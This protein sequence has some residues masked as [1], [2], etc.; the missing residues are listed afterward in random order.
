[1]VDARLT[2]YPFSRLTMALA[3][4]IFFSDC[5][6]PEGNTV[7]WCLAGCL[8]VAVALM[9][10]SH[11]S[12][13]YRFR[14]TFGVISVVAF[15][16]LG[17]M[18]TQQEKRKVQYDWPADEATYIGTLAEAPVRKARS[19]QLTL[20]VEAVRDSLL[21]WVPVDKKAVVYQMP[22][23]TCSPLEIGDRICFNVRMSSPSVEASPSVGFDYGNHLLRS[24]VGGRAMLYP[25]KLMVLSADEGTSISLK[26]K[27]LRWRERV[28]SVF[29][30]WQLTP[31]VQAV[32]AAL[33]V[34]DK[35]GLS[36]DLKSSY[37]AAGTSHVLALSGLHVGLLSA[38]LL[39]VLSPLRWVRGG[40][41]LLVGVS[42]C[43][44]WLFAFIT[45]LSP[46]V[47]RAVSMFTF[48]EVAF[49]LS[50][51]RFS[52]FYPL[53]LTAF[54]ML[55]Y[56]PFYLFDVSFQLSFVA[57]FSILFFYPYF[58]GL[59]DISNRAL[60][61]VYQAVCLSLSAQL[62]TLPLV[63][64][65]FGAFP[66]YF[67]LANIVVTPLAVCILLFTMLSLAFSSLPFFAGWFLLPLQCSVSLLN[68]TM[69]W[70]SGL[71][72]AQITSIHTSVMQSALMLFG[73]YVLALLMSKFS[74]RRLACLLLTLNVLAFSVLTDSYYHK[75][76]L[77]FYHKSVYLRSNR[78]MS[79]LTSVHHI[80]KVKDLHIALMNDARWVGYSSLEKKK[81]HYAYLCGGFRGD[82]KGLS[83]LFDI[84]TI[85]FDSGINEKYKKRLM[86]ECDALGINY[87]DLSGK[88]SYSILL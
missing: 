13:G 59:F 23:S 8:L 35:S 76:T 30:S 61:F 14:F 74:F 46:S 2:S 56:C 79:K 5:F 54:C 81:L 20:H 47:V 49:I 40:R 17:A 43:V 87:I 32:I 42:V 83:H 12:G 69:E 9:L 37:S 19:W 28:V 27:A 80:Y 78:E 82:I 38:I 77:L 71:P 62:G 73:L 55:V 4:G 57:V 41:W 50:E 31:D 34:G 21:G 85:V 84:H 75:D 45:G 7:V 24:G 53:V 44:L 52:G 3:V 33:T 70:V 1:M 58:A 18:L 6:L 15:G 66:V 16:L 48:Y 39:L 65:Y 67:L 29:R 26:Q 60:R 72:G 64:Y 11:R 88:G 36:S 51:S 63:L 22:D 25:G 10:W 86:Q 68:A